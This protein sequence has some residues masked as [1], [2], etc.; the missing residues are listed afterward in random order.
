MKSDARLTPQEIVEYL[1]AD[2]IKCLV[3]GKEFQELRS[4]HLALH[5]LSVQEYKAR[6]GL[7]KAPLTCAELI[8]RRVV[9]LAPAFQAYNSSLT[10]D[11]RRRIGDSAKSRGL[12]SM[13]LK[14]RSMPKRD[15][16]ITRLKALGMTNTKLAELF[17]ITDGRVWQIL[18]RQG[19][20]NQQV[21]DD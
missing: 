4:P 20:L 19:Q 7:P 3:C 14:S 21:K 17:A 12:A 10:T 5:G 16:E 1:S 11:D 15:A 13:G 8:A 9:W 2:R 18:S 6:Y